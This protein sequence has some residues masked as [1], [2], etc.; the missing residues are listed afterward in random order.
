MAGVTDRP[1]GHR[2]IQFYDS[3]GK[4]KTIRLG[5]IASKPAH[6][7]CR[8]VELIQ[9]A[10]ITGT[11]LDKESAEWLSKIGNELR[12][13]LV[14]VGLIGKQEHAGKVRLKEFLDSYIDSRTDLKPRSI[15]RLGQARRFLI[16]FFGEEAFVDEFTTNDGERWR[17]WLL[18]KARGGKSGLAENNVRRH[19]G[20]ARQ[21]FKAA[22]RQKLIG[23]NPF[24]EVPT[25]VHGNAKRLYFVTR[26]EADALI[27]AAPSLAWKAII[28]LARYGGLRCPSEIFSLAWA[29]VDLKAGKMTIR[30][31]KTE[32]HRD[33]GIRVCPI[34]PE[35]R[36][37]LEALRKARK[38]GDKL[39]LAD[40]MISAKRQEAD[41]E[42]NLRTYLLRIIRKAGLTPWPKLYQNMRSSCE[43]ELLDRYPTK[44]VCDW[45][46]NSQAVAM[47]HYAQVTDRH[48]AA[49][50]AGKSILGTAEAEPEAI[51]S[52]K[53]NPPESATAGQSGRKKQESPRK[54]AVSGDLAS[55]G[56]VLRKSLIRPTGVEPVTFGSEDRCSIQLSY[57]RSC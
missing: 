37:H 23:D 20:R 40:L 53:A 57:G 19:C 38:S 42:T 17:I 26:E 7:V 51:E 15:E 30:A 31:P 3:D 43:T 29:D 54:R 41:G 8:R 39:V 18:T 33:G 34:F 2:W 13:K 27:A 5:K 12:D 24:S 52:L 55:P 56:K 11:S 47:K 45:I 16:G 50:I 44:A 48:F 22:I 1:N 35:L 21:F 49:A 28:A 46:G 6:E 32:R 14:A 36:P 9:Q 4:R 10:K 25:A